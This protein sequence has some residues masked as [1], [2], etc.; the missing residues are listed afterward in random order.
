MGDSG[1]AR[2]RLCKQARRAGVGGCVRL[3][4]AL[5]AMCADTNEKRLKM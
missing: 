2:E 4:K 3:V 5:V 1:C